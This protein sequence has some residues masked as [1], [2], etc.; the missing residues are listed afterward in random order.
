MKVVGCVTWDGYLFDLGV[1]VIGYA[2]EPVI[3]LYMRNIFPCPFLAI[4]IRIDE[5]EV[6][7]VPDL[8]HLSH[9]TS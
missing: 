6:P 3:R 7:A 4:S 8:S 5:R 9:P 2:Q 1:V